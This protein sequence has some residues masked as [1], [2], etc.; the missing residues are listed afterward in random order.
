MIVSVRKIAI[1]S[2]AIGMTAFFLVGF[3]G[4]SHFGM[5]MG[6]DGEMSTGDCPFMSGGSVCNMNPLEHLASW[7]EMFAVITNQVDYAFAL[8]IL[9]TLSFVRLVYPAYFYSPPNLLRQSQYFAKR[10]RIS[11]P[12]VLQEF[13]SNGILNPK[14]F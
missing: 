5:N 7:Q 1:V 2:L 10:K 11:A 13:F 6:A 12:S 3:L 14:L 4:I 8:L 9:I